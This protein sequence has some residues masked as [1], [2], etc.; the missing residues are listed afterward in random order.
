MKLEAGLDFATHSRV[1]QL[2]MMVQPLGFPPLNQSGPSERKRACICLYREVSM[3][4]SF[5]GARRAGGDNQEISERGKLTHSLDKQREGTVVLKPRRELSG[6]S[7]S[8]TMAVW[9][10]L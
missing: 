4:S 8:H 2:E 6:G 10:K 1:D 5:R 9:P 7:Q 3:G